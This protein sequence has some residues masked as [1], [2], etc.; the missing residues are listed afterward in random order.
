MF[1]N[2][3]LYSTGS[4]LSST[5]FNT[6]KSQVGYYKWSNYSSSQK[7]IQRTHYQCN[8]NTTY[9]RSDFISKL[10][11]LNGTYTIGSTT[12]VHSD[13][14]WYI[15][16]SLAPKYTLHK[17]TS[18]LTLLSTYD[19]DT[20]TLT[21]A[22]IDIS[23]KGRNKLKL[24]LTA[25]GTDYKTY[26]SND[27]TNWQEVTDIASDTPKELEVDGWNNLYIKIETNTSTINNIDIAY[28]KD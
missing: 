2:S 22:P 3:T 1:S 13:G 7:K 6:T 8:K 18:D 12:K 23:N 5:G 17:Y 24:T 26:I 28:Y 10:I 21:T 4:T 27:N 15:R 20:A 25:S 9:S 14:Y 11:A 19:V 16:N